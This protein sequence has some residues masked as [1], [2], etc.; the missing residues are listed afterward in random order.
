MRYIRQQ[1]FF[2][3]LC[4][5]GLSVFSGCSKRS[6]KKED[7]PYT[8]LSSSQIV[9]AMGAGWNAASSLEVTEEL[10]E[11]VSKSGFKSIRIPLYYEEY[12]VD[13]KWLN[14]TQQ[15]IDYC[16]KNDLYVVLTLA[17]KNSSTDSHIW[18]DRTAKEKEEAKDTYAAI[19]EQIANRYKEYNEHVLFEGLTMEFAQ[20]PE[21][22]YYQDINTYNQIFVDTVRRAEGNNGKR[23]LIVSG[24]NSKIRY[25]DE[26]KGFQIPTEHY[27]SKQVPKGENRIMIGVHYFEPWEFCK[28]ENTVI[29]QWGED[30]RNLERCSMDSGE[31]DLGK[32]FNMLRDNFIAK[33]YPCVITEYGANNK[34][35]YDPKNTMYRADFCKKVCRKSMQME[36]V[37][38]YFDDS[39]QGDFGM[40]LFN[41]E[42][43][44]L[45]Q[46]EILDAIMGIY[47]PKREGMAYNIQLSDSDLELETGSVTKSSKQLTAL[48][49]PGAYNGKLTWSSSDESVAT[50]SSEGRVTAQGLGS[51]VICVEAESGV[52]ARCEVVVVNSHNVKLRLYCLESKTWTT[53]ASNDYAEVSPEGGTY[54]LTLKAPKDTFLNMGTIFIKDQDVEGKVAEQS[55]FERAMIKINSVSFNGKKF[56]ILKNKKYG[57]IN[58]T[59]TF[60]CCL[61]NQ[62]SMYEKIIKEVNPSSEKGPMQFTTGDYKEKDNF[63]SVEFTVSDIIDE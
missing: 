17:C 34:S 24:W 1:C 21:L 42:T 56:T 11:E 55:R 20:E 18:S 39:I 22:E 4:V 59:H 35:K 31:V 26:N 52:S 60:D 41:W 50:V 23:W 40:A 19:W 2:I 32:N 63:L 36:C 46:P 62:W 8:D 47:H 5:V 45:I 16:I 6:S 3:V 28:S 37:P 57:A 53:V 14:S 38:M 12:T 27:L 58:M 49:E 54:R 9:Y 10:I 15:V 33:G 61:V 51:A 13:G 30:A 43:R 29:T 25:T 48:V 7:N 44:E